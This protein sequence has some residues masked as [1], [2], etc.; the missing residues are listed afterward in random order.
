MLSKAIEEMLNEKD[1]KSVLGDFFKQAEEAS[2]IIPVDVG[3]TY[4]KSCDNPR[5]ERAP[6]KFDIIEFSSLDNIHIVLKDGK[7]LKVTSEELL[8]KLEAYDEKLSS[9]L[10][11]HYGSRYR[12]T[13]L[14][15]KNILHIV[16]SKD[17]T[18]CIEIF[19]VIEDTQN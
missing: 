19:G 18:E 3:Y 12:F 11:E 1:L 16:G 7:D 2:G 17:Y 9:L 6:M 10:A 8:K 5:K 15:R 14:P 4:F 13:I